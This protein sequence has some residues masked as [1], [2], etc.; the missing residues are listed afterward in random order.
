MYIA[1]DKT[2]H[3]GP[4]PPADT[5]VGWLEIEAKDIILNNIVLPTS[6]IETV[7]QFVTAKALTSNNVTFD[8]TALKFYKI[9]ASSYT[10]KTYDP[11][12]GWEDKEIVR[13]EDNSLVVL[14]EHKVDISDG[15][16]SFSQDLSMY[17]DNGV[18]IIS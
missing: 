7:R 14:L 9:N 1:V 4:N 17:V 5:S 8:N 2:V 16:L 12:V 11:E 3:V 15:K 18:L 10:I 13:V 6:I